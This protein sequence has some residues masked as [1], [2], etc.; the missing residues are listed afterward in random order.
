MRLP[1][2]VWPVPALLRASELS[3][4]TESSRS[5]IAIRIDG[6]TAFNTV[7]TVA[8]M[9]PAPMSSTSYSS[10]IAPVYGPRASKGTSGS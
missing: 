6:S 10:A 2:L 9:M 7:P 1:R 5:K 3:P 4:D 8:L